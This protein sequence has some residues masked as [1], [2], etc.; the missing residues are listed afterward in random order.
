[1]RY[2]GTITKWKDEEGYGFITPRG[3]GKQVFL[4][5]R[6]FNGAPGRPVGDEVVTYEVSSDDK[7]RERATNVRY[8]GQEESEPS[9]I[10]SSP[11]IQWAVFA[12]LGGLFATS[13][14]SRLPYV[15]PIA[16]LA[17]SLVAYA[18]YAIDKFK[19][20]NNLWRV[21]E[22]ILH[23]L[24]LMGGWP[25]AML[26]QHQLRHKLRKPEFMFIFWTT[27]ALNCLAI[28]LLCFPASGWAGH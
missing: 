24:A 17:M 19:A 14:L 13:A 27:V 3:G 15:V 9:I 20:Q 26:A 12:I 10:H 1:M 16:V 2:Q 5:I 6:A 18:V 7:G 8:V 21:P 22:A 11:T 4:H 28:A 25:G 23:L